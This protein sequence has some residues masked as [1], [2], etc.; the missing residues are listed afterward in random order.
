MACSQASSS[1]FPSQY[2]PLHYDRRQ[3]ALMVHFAAFDELDQLSKASG[4]RT[5]QIRAIAAG[6]RA[7]TTGVLAHFNLEK[8]GEEFVWNPA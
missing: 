3:V 8:A 6:R 2:Q 4:T 1:G 7:P 5:P